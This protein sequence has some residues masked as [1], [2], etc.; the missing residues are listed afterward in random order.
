MW[1]VTCYLQS[2]QVQYFLRQPSREFDLD[3]NTGKLTV[4]KNVIDIG[5]HHSNELFGKFVSLL[6][7]EQKDTYELTAYA[8]DSGNPSRRAN[9][10]I[11]I[12]ISDVNDH[13]PEFRYPTPHGT[14]SLLNIS[15]AQL[16]SQ[17][18]AHVHAND[19][20][21]GRNGDIEYSIIRQNSRPQL[22]KVKRSGDGDL[23]TDVQEKSKIKVSKDKNS[24]SNHTDSPDLKETTTVQDGVN[25]TVETKNIS[26]TRHVKWAPLSQILLGGPTE[27]HFD[28]DS[29]SGQLFLIH[30][31]FD[32]S[33]PVDVKLLIQATD[34]GQPSKSSTAQLTLHIYPVTMT[35]E[36]D[37]ENNQNTNNNN[38]MS[39]TD[40]RRNLDFNRRISSSTNAWTDHKNSRP[41]YQ[42]AG[43]SVSSSGMTSNQ[44]NI[45]NY[46][47]PAIVG[48]IVAMIVLVLLLCL[49]LIILRRR[50]IMDTRKLPNK[51]M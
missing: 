38:F 20:D 51:G 45:T 21:T 12:S 19:S 42:R 9:T 13:A 14:G 50:F 1:A 17:I 36:L 44:R 29:Y 47:W 11:H 23:L 34:G 41:I 32:C 22:Q 7:R 27:E 6:D 43:F 4:R 25:K 35:N 28:I 24:Q 26:N 48:L 8:E 40:I 31:I 2:L 16:G 33:Q 37:S 5:K 15:C 39:V 49:M 46:H 3:K 18:I 30:P 10:V